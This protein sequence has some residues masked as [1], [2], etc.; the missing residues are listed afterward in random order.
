MNI[1]VPCMDMFAIN[2]ERKLNTYASFFDFSAA[3]N[4]NNKMPVLFFIHGGGYNLLSG[5]EILLGADYLI[6][7]NIIIV[8][9]NYRL[10]V[11]GFLS[12]NTP[13]YSGNMGLKDQQMALKFVY[14]H[15]GN[16]GGDNT[17]ITISGN[18][19]G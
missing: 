4:P 8:T 12:L 7:G 2:L 10:G 17:R 6:E 13:E 19:A 15:I 1:F 9:I 5:D 3:A 14:D 16:F 11:L 18:S